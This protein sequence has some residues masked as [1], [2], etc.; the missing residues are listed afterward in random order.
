MRDLLPVLGNLMNLISDMEDFARLFH[1]TRELLIAWN[2][3]LLRN[4]NAEA[5]IINIYKIL[6]MKQL[7]SRL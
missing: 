6:Q 3:I 2:I 5:I 4:D 1:V 7:E